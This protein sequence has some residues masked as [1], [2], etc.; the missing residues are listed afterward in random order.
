MPHRRP[1]THFATVGALLGAF[2]LLLAVTAAASLSASAATPEGQSV[3]IVH[4]LGTTSVPRN[5]ER[6]VV[7]DFGALDTLDRLGV[8]TSVAGLPKANVPPYLAHF[9][10]DDYVNVGTLLEPDY[11]A[12][13]AVKPDLII[14]SGRTSAHYEQLSKLAPTIFVGVDNDDYVASLLQNARTLAAIFDRSAEAEAAAAELQDAVDRV[15]RSAAGKNAL[16]LLVTGGRANAYGPGSRY[17]FVHSDLGLAPVDDAIVDSTHGQVIS[18]EYV[19][20][21]DPDILL[22]VDRD[23]VVADGGPQTARQVVENE[24]VKLTRA[25]ERGAIAYLDP[26]YW[27]LSGG[28]LT[29]FVMMAEDVEAALRAA[30]P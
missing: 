29:S 27:Y 30:G 19:L 28:G 17:G 2:T 3:T 1:G 16:L 10:T 21:R 15:R 24:L 13:N 20:V 5:P 23:A 6:V 25:Y 18:W 11:E 7:F 22:V 26:T 8:G 12:V 9:Q 4:D 14:I